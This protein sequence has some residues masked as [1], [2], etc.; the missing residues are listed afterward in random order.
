MHATNRKMLV[1]LQ[2][3][4][5]RTFDVRTFRFVTEFHTNNYVR[6]GGTFEP[7]KMGVDYSMGL[8]GRKM[9]KLARPHPNLDVPLCRSVYSPCGNQVWSGCEDGRVLVW[10]AD[11][12]D[13]AA[14]YD[15]QV[16]DEIGGVSPTSAIVDVAFHPHDHIVA[17]CSLGDSQPVLIFTWDEEFP[18]VES[19]VKSQGGF[20]WEFV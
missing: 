5:I 20:F 1:H 17:F 14:I 9:G 4:G 7:S 10:K 8:L 6:H 13:I 19:M 16:C 3:H 15:D 11:T 2:G 18:T 12:G